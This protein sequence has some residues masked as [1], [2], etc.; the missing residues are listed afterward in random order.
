MKLSAYFDR[1]APITLVADA[2]PVGLGAV[3]LQ[4]QRGINRVIA[5]G[6]RSLSEAESRYSQ[7]EREAL[8]VVWAC[9]HFKMYL[10]GNKFRFITDHKPLVHIYSN[11]GS[12]PTPRLKRWS[13]RLQ[14]YD[15]QIVYEPGASN[16]ADL[17]SGLPVSSDL[18]EVIDDAKDYILMLSVD[19]V[20]HAMLWS[21]IQVASDFCPVIQTIKGAITTGK[22]DKCSVSVKAVKDELSVCDG[23]ILRGSRILIPSSLRGKVLELAHEGHQGIVKCKQRLRSKDVVAEGGSRC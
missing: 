20:P 16:I 14:P 12:K 2:S 3:L 11:A 9:E 5:Y 17:M 22:W 7:T 4:E 15:L 18:P 13:L 19:A 6:H 10:L 8:G 21:E 1:N 23:V